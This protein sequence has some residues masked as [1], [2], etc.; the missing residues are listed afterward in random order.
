MSNTKIPNEE[1][2]IYSIVSKN[3]KRV[4]DIGC[5]DDIDYHE[6][7]SDC[8][9]HLFEPSTDA[10]KSIKVKIGKLGKH[11]II[12]NEFGLSDI[13]K[14]NC[15]YY[16]NVQSFKPHW[17]V[18]SHDTGHRYSLKKLDDYVNDNK[19][20]SIDMVKIDVE[21]LDYNVILGGV[22]TI[23]KITSYI[24]LE[25]SGG[26]KQYLDKLTNFNF[27]LMVEPRLL[28]VINKHNNTGTDFNKGLVN[29][30]DKEI[31]FIDNTISKTGAGG[32]IFG[33]HKN[34]NVNEV[35][36]D[37]LFFKVI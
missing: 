19:I 26:I 15:V 2:R 12:L 27:Y 1:L 24:Q 3:F 16:D 9:Y 6:I 33:I 30:T 20:N 29:L 17:Y 34:I 18:P 8:E 11:N 36:K 4:F 37:E 23:Q 10:I 25:Y 13:N 5:R 31:S 21:G 28:E 7:K 32:N 14:D 22:E 35:Y